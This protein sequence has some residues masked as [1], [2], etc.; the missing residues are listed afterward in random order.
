MICDEQY[1]V[2]FTYNTVHKLIATAP[3]STDNLSSGRWKGK[4]SK[5]SKPIKK[6]GIG[7]GMMV[8]VIIIDADLT[9]SVSEFQR[10]GAATEKDLHPV[11]RRSI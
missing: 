10:V 3:K 9:L 5:G 11:N 1:D 2:G 8:N 7:I 6:R 4:P